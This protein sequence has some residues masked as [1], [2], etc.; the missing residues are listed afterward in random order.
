VACGRWQAQRGHTATGRGRVCVGVGLG[1]VGCAFAQ[2]DG[3]RRSA[4]ILLPVEVEPVRGLGWELL[5][6]R[7]RRRPEAGA[8]WSYRHRSRSGACGRWA[9]SGWPLVERWRWQAD[10]GGLGVAGRAFA[11]AGGCRRPGRCGSRVRA[12]RRM[13]AAWALLVARSGRQADAG[14]LGVGGRAGASWGMVGCGR[15]LGGRWAGAEREL[16]RRWLAVGGRGRWRAP[17]A[18]YARSGSLFRRCLGVMV[19]ELARARGLRRKVPS[20]GSVGSLG[21]GGRGSRELAVG[22]PGN[23]S[24]GRSCSGRSRAVG[25]PGNKSMG[26][27]CSGRARAVGRFGNKSRGRSCSGRSGPRVDFGRLRLYGRWCGDVAAC[28]VWRCWVGGCRFVSG[29]GRRVSGV[30]GRGSGV[31]GRPPANRRSAGARRLV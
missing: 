27:S 25:C 22:R 6:A 9:G 23:K 11:Q 4:V 3:G 19:G 30:G 12:G 18:Q 26:R 8:A 2:A 1:A 31:G 20:E 15:A 10:A 21:A 5:A 16:G 24:M 28:G 17:G 7:S 14:G 29:V 13:W